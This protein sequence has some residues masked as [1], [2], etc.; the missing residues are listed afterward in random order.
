MRDPERIDTIMEQLKLLWKQYPEM[1]LGQ[2]VTNVACCGCIKTVQDEFYIEDDQ[3][4]YGIK[5]VL[6]EGWDY[7]P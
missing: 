3:W 2:L 6:A 7:G 5:K 4:L 1:R